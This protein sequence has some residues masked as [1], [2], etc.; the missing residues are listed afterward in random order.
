MPNDSELIYESYLMSIQALNEARGRKKVYT[1]RVKQIITDPETGEQRLESYYEMMQRLKRAKLAAE[2]DIESEIEELTKPAEEPETQEEPVETPD[3]NAEESDVEDEPEDDDDV[4]VEEPTALSDEVA[5]FD[6]STT[7]TTGNIDDAPTDATTQSILRF[8][9][10]TPAT[11]DEIVQHLID[12]DVDPNEAKNVV[13]SL[14]NVGVIQPFFANK[15]TPTEE[16]G[17]VELPDVEETDIGDEDVLEP[18]EVEDVESA[19]SSYLPKPKVSKRA[20]TD[21]ERR[22]EFIRKVMDMRKQKEALPEEEEPD[23]N[24]PDDDEDTSYSEEDEPVV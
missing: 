2:A 24:E 10:D 11:G 1:D 6:F 16:P 21:D 19:V 20:L 23:Y 9:E 18:N 13:V 3:T 14:S 17:E 8:I 15:E 12:N 7:F 4:E 5:N 22:E